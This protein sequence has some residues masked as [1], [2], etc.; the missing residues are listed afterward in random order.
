MRRQKSSAPMPR[1]APETSWTHYNPALMPSI[2]L[3]TDPPSAIDT[4]LL[5]V[6]VFDGEAAAD[7]LPAVDAA[8][9]GEV[10][11]AIVSGEIRGRL[12]EF[13]VTPSAGDTWK[14]RRIAIAGAGKAAEFDTERLRKVATASALMAR[15]RRM[16][17][18]AF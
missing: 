3:V 12:Y 8:S 2:R 14:P 9:H 6:P 4:D 18:L 5:V 16:A 17:R 11:R 13:F 7:A 1:A 15:G 10:R